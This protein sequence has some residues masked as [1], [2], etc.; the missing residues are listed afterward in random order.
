M[1]DDNSVVGTI[2][3]EGAAGAARG[4]AYGVGLAISGGNPIV[5]LLAAGAVL[6]FQK[7]ILK[8]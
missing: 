3:E 2:V 7:T 5:G 6:L 8:D 4:I 1:S